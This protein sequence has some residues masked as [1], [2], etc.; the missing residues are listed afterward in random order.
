MQKALP[1]DEKHPAVSKRNYRV[2]AA[3]R[4][5]DATGAEAEWRKWLGK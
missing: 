3:E 4:T 5:L 2:I 1:L